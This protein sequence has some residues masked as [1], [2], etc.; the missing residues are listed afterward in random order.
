MREALYENTSKPQIVTVYYE[1]LLEEICTCDT[2]EHTFTRLFLTGDTAGDQTVNAYLNSLYKDIQKELDSFETSYDFGNEF[3]PLPGGMGSYM[4]V[5]AYPNYLDDNYI[6][7]TIAEETYYSGGAHPNTWSEEYVFDRR[8]GTRISITDMVENPP[9]EICEIA[10][11]YVEAD[12]PGLHFYENPEYRASILEDFRFFLSEERI[13]IHFNTYELG[14]YAEGN[15]DYIIP[16]WEFDLKPDTIICLNIEKVRYRYQS[17]LETKEPP[18]PG[19]MEELGNMLTEQLKAGTLPDLLAE[20]ASGY[21]E[22]SFEEK[23][24]KWLQTR[25]AC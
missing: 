21:R 4:R 8:T 2:L 7:I 20:H 11:A 13:G 18:L 22:L 5:T 16:F 23:L 19:Y 9:E 3:Y 17:W 15:E 14:S 1:N 10:A 6:G 24:E 12:H 25:T